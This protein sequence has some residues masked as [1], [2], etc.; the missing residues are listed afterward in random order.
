MPDDSQAGA[1]SRHLTTRQMRMLL[2]IEEHRSVL[3]ASRSLKVAQPAL[4][5][6]LSDLEG[7]LQGELF[8]TGKPIPE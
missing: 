1:L 8:L 4:S 3:K 2:A 6:S 5:R 7:V